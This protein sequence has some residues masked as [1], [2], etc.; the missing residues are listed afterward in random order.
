M[1]LWMVL[2]VTVVLGAGLHSAFAAMPAV[3]SA[4]PDFTLPS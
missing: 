4:A 2:L 1:R 3:G